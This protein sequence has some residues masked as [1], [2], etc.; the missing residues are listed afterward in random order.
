MWCTY[1]FSRKI[2]ISTNKEF[3]FVLVSVRFVSEVFITTFSPCIVGIN[4]ARTLARSRKTSPQTSQVNSTKWNFRTTTILKLMIEGLVAIHWIELPCQSLCNL[5][6][7]AMVA[8]CFNHCFK[9]SGLSKGNRWR[10]APSF[11]ISLPPLQRIFFH[12][13]HES[14]SAWES[15]KY[16]IS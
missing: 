6:I 11:L 10:L 4:W 7:V 3:K 8:S 2:R 13:V 9:I 12:N 1:T 16:P 14:R 15:A 5:V